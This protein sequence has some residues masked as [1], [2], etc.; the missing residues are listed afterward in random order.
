M[1]YTVEELTINDSFIAYCTRQNEKDIAF[2]NE[3]LYQHPEELLTIEEAR[4]L[5]LGLK[6]ML[7]KKQNELSADD[8]RLGLDLIAVPGKTH[9][10]DFYQE[11]PE[12]PARGRNK[13]EW[14][15]A[16]SVILLLGTGLWFL[17]KQ[18]LR[19]GNTS[20][21]LSAGIT[22]TVPGDSIGSE[23]GEYKTL[24]LSDGTKVTLNAQSALL[25]SAGFGTKNRDVRLTGEAFFEVAHNR[26]LPFIVQASRYKI[27][28]VGTKFNVKDYKNDAYSE[29]SLLEGK[30]QILLPSGNRD[31][32]YKTLEVNQKFVIHTTAAPEAPLQ[33]KT[34]IT[35]LSY[36][37]SQQNIETAW[38]DHSL[39]FDNTPLYEIKNILERKYAIT[40][41]IADS[42]VANYRY[43]ASFQN[44]GA[45]EILKALQ[46]SYHF[47]Y[48][49]DGN[50]IIINK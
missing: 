33:E 27:K 43:T 11:K 38:V 16:A 10:H 25:V 48:K 3:Y 46:L 17:Y 4:K 35:P 49:K 12:Q 13:K 8:A 37:D 45:D 39:V 41:E 1:I 24:I 47:S 50:K 30:V 18:P 31:R 29:T 42:D 26:L 19:T 28:A 40:V 6:F 32:V 34:E 9:S 36:D 14:L 20:N 44:E 5:V 2:W 22:A 21:R 7:H 23:R 15:A